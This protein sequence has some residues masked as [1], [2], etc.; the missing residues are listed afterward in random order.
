M[1][2]QAA[3]GLRRSGIPVIKELADLLEWYDLAR[4]CWH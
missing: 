1:L 4:A 2:L 3:D